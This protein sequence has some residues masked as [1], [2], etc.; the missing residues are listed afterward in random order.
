MFDMRIHG[1]QKHVLSLSLAVNRVV[2][3]RVKDLIRATPFGQPIRRLLASNSMDTM[4]GYDAN[5]LSAAILN[6]CSGYRRLSASPLSLGRYTHKLDEHEKQTLLDAR[7]LDTVDYTNMLN[8][9][10][11]HGVRSVPV[12]VPPWLWSSAKQA[13]TPYV[14][15]TTMWTRVFLHNYFSKN[16]IIDDV[17]GIF[18][19]LQLGE[20][21]RF[22]EHRLF[23]SDETCILES[24]VFFDG[25]HLPLERGASIVCV[26][27]HPSMSRVKTGEFRFITSIETLRGCAATHSLSLNRLKVPEIMTNG[28]KAYFTPLTDELH[29]VKSMGDQSAIFKSE[30]NS[31]AAERGT[32]QVQKLPASNEPDTGWGALSYQS[33]IPVRTGQG[34]YIGT[35]CNE[36]IFFS[37]RSRCSWPTRSCHFSNT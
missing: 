34:F 32:L 11:A 20:T 1:F 23:A 25:E 30:G 6:K 28:T 37:P 7:Q 33:A 16:Y 3:R 13:Y 8:M 21:L 2:P 36:D 35:N 4:P 26:P 22:I 17:V 31:F 5:E 9:M 10:Y 14:H 24:D 18:I 12:I 15:D 19:F 27:V 29:M